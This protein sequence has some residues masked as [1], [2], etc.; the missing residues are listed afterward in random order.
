MLPP[1]FP[2]S[3]LR[4]AP[5]EG[6]E[7]HK[8][9]RRSLCPLGTARPRHRAAQPRE[10]RPGRAPGGPREKSARLSPPHTRGRT[11]LPPAPPHGA[12]H[13]LLHCRP[14]AVLAAPSLPLLTGPCLGTLSPSTGPHLGLPLTAAHSGQPPRPSAWPV[15]A[16]RG[17]P[18]PALPARPGHRN[19]E[20]Q[21]RR[22]PPLESTTRWRRPRGRSPALAVIATAPSKA[23]P[24]TLR[25]NPHPSPAPQGTSLDV[26]RSNSVSLKRRAAP[27]FS[28]RGRQRTLG[29]RDAR[30]SPAL[31]PTAPSHWLP[32]EK[33]RSLP[34]GRGLRVL[35]APNRAPRSE[36]SPGSS[37]FRTALLEQNP[38]PAVPART[39]PTPGSSGFGTALLD[40][41]PLPAGLHSVFLDANSHTAIPPSHTQNSP[42]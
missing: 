34:N 24:I 11:G 20:P 40:Q 7:G 29:T 25:A 37:G 21:R 12:A 27:P 33:G 39:E 22:S 28:E 41:N 26:D 17:S 32:T 2:S 9:R 13:G 36:P 30:Q 14:I 16:R 3:F 38:L 5:V 6:K 4:A 19:A 8:G 23:R 10:P 42:A 35:G 18:G 1:R 31:S 15:P